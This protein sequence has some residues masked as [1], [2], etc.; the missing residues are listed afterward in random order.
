MKNKA[1]KRSLLI[2]PASVPL[3]GLVLTLSTTTT[4]TNVQ[5]KTVLGT[6]WTFDKVNI[7]LQDNLWKNYNSLPTSN[8]NARYAPYRYI[9]IFNSNGN[10]NFN[11][12]NANW[13]YRAVGDSWFRLF[14]ATNPGFPNNVNVSDWTGTNYATES[15]TLYSWQVDGFENK[16]VDH[17]PWWNGNGYNASTDTKRFKIGYNL[18]NKPLHGS[19]T[20]G[21]QSTFYTGAFYFSNDMKIASDIK[22]HLYIKVDDRN[23]SNV[24]QQKTYTI[25]LKEEKNANLSDYDISP[26]I[27]KVQRVNKDPLR[28]SQAGDTLEAWLT[29]YAYLPYYKNTPTSYT[30]GLSADLLSQKRTWDNYRSSDKHNGMYDILVSTPTNMSDIRSRGFQ[31]SNSSGSYV[32]FGLFQKNLINNDRPADIIYNN[33]GGLFVFNIEMDK[34]LDYLVAG[35]VA[36]VEFEPYNDVANASTTTFFGNTGSSTT[37]KS[38]FGSAEYRQKDDDDNQRIVSGFWKIADRSESQ[39]KKFYTLELVDSELG[40]D[41]YDPKSDAFPETTLRITENGNS[42]INYEINKDGINRNKKTISIK[43]VYQDTKAVNSRNSLRLTSTINSRDAKKWK[44]KNGSSLTASPLPSSRFD[45]DGIEFNSITYTYTDLELA[46]KYVDTK[47]WLNKGQKSYLKMALDNETGFNASNEYSKTELLTDWKT[48]IDTLDKQQESIEKKYKEI[49][50]FPLSNNVYDSSYNANITKKII[51]ALATK[52]SKDNL[53][54]IISRNINKINFRST[55]YNTESG[56]IDRTTSTEYSISNPSGASYNSLKSSMDSVYNALNNYLTAVINSGKTE[57]EKYFAKLEQYPITQQNSLTYSGNY[58]KAKDLIIN[59]IKDQVKDLSSKSR[60]SPFANLDA[61]NEQIKTIIELIGKVNKLNNDKN[62]V[63]SQ[64]E[65]YKQS[66]NDFN[67]LGSFEFASSTS[68]INLKALDAFDKNLTNASDKTIENIFEST[69]IL[70]KFYNDNNDIFAKQWIEKVKG[71]DGAINEFNTEIDKFNYLD[72]NQ[73]TTAKNDLKNALSTFNIFSYNDNTV[74]LIVNNAFIK[75]IND[76]MSSA[77]VTAKATAKT[78]ISA[79]NE[80]T[81]T[82]KNQVKKEIDNATLYKDSYDA[83]QPFVDKILIGSDKNIKAIV[84]KW[85]DINNERG[86]IKDYTATFDYPDKNIE[87]TT[88]DKK[89]VSQLSISPDDNGLETEVISISG[90]NDTGTLTVTYRVVKSSDKTNVYTQDKTYDITGFANEQNRVNKLSATPDYKDASEKPNIQASAV[91]NRNNNTEDIAWVLPTKTQIYA[92]SVRY[93]GY[94]DI[95]G[96]IKIAYKLQSTVNASAISDEKT[97]EITGFETESTR[98]NNLVKQDT[99]ANKN[100]VLNITANPIKRA[101]DSTLNTDYTIAL[102]NNYGTNNQV[103]LTNLSSPTANDTD[104][105]VSYTYKL[106][107]TRTK[108]DLV[109][110]TEE[111]VNDNDIYSDVSASQTRTG[112]LTQA[113]YEQNQKDAKK[114]AIDDYQSLND[115]QKTALKNEIDQANLDK[116]DKIAQNASDLNDA[117]EAYNG[118]TNNI[119][120]IKEGTDYTQADNDNKSALDNAVNQQKTDVNKT[121]GPNLSLEE[122]KKRTKAIQ[123]AISDLNGDEKLQEAKD[124]AI[125]KINSDYSSLTDKQ[126]EK[127]I[128]LINEQTTI[129]GVTTQDATNSELNSS[130]KTLRDYIAGQ[131]T[132]TAGDDYIYTTNDLRAAYDGNP[133]KNNN[134]KGGVIKEAEDLV[135]ALNTNNNDNLMNK[136]TIDALNKKIKGAIDALNGQ[137]RYGEELA[138]LNGLSLALAKVKD[139]N[140]ATDTASEVDTNEVEFISSTMPDN[141]TPV[142]LV[143]SNPN[144]LTGK[145][146]LSYKYQSTKE[147]LEN[148]KSTKVYTLNNNNALSTLTEQQRVDAILADSN[149]PFTINENDTNA[150]DRNQLPSAVAKE[151]I[152]A[153]NNPADLNVEG[154]L[155]SIE[156][157]PNNDNGTLN[158]TFKIAST[159]AILNSNNDP[160]NPAVVSTNTRTITLTG[161]KTTLQAEKEKVIEYINN[162]VP[163]AKKQAL[164]DELAN[165]NTLDEVAKVQL[166]AEIEKA[167]ADATNNYPYLNNNQLEAYKTDLRS[168]TS[169]EG[170]QTHSATASTLNAKMKELSDAVKTELTALTKKTVENDQNNDA[171]TAIV[172][173]LADADKKQAYD[174]ALSA[175]Q[176][177]LNKTNGA[178]SELSAVE[179]VLSN[180][181]TAYGELNGDQNQNA[182]NERID[183]LN[184]LTEKQKAQL[185]ENIANADAQADAETIVEAAETLDAKIAD[186]KKQLVELNNYKNNDVYKLDKENKDA[187]DTALENIQNALDELSNKD[188][189]SVSADD[190]NSEATNLDTK[191]S[192]ANQAKDLLDG[193]RSDLKDKLNNFDNLT[194]ANKQALINLINA[195]DKELS[196]EKVT[197]YLNQALNLAKTNVNN[198]ID[199]LTHLTPAEKQAYKDAVNEAELNTADGEK[200]DKNLNDIL[201]QAKADDEAKKALIKAINDKQYLNDAQKAALIDKVY[202]TPLAELNEFE[203]DAT[204]L[205]NAMKTYSEIATVDKE[206]IKYKEAFEDRQAEYNNQITNR[207]NALNKTDGANLSLD[208]VNE[209]IKKLNKAINNLNGE[210]RLQRAKN[211]AIAKIT[212]DNPTYT[213]LTDAQKTVLINQINAQTSIADVNAVDAKNKQIN[214]LTKMLK[215]NINGE[216]GIKES[217]HYTGSEPD[218]KSEY[219]EAIEA[220]KELLAKLNEPNSDTNN[221]VDLDR[222]KNQN[223]AVHDAI[224]A[225]NGEQNIKK[226]R[227]EALAKLEELEHINNLQKAALTTQIDNAT[228]PEKIDEIVANATNLN[229]QMGLLKEELANQAPVKDTPK[230]LNADEDPRNKYDDLLNE[231]TFL[232]D[233]ENGGAQLSPEAVADLIN[234][235]KVA[236]QALDGNEKFDEV[237]QQIIADIDALEHLNDAQKAALKESLNEKKLIADLKQVGEDAKLLDNAMAEIK[238]KAQEIANDLAQEGNYKYVAATEEPKTN[239]D[240]VKA[241]VDALVVPSG[242]NLNLKEVQDLQKALIAAEKALDGETN[243]DYFRNKAIEKIQSNPNLTDEEKTALIDQLNNV[244][245]PNDDEAITKEDFLNNLDKIV[246]KAK[247]IETIKNDDNLTPEQKTDLIDDIVKA[248]STQ[249]NYDDVLD[250]IKAKEDAYKTLNN[251]DSLTEDDKAKLS[252]NIADIEPNSPKFNEELNNEKIKQD[253]IKEI[254][255]DDNLPETTKNNLA[256]EI[257]ELDNKQAKSA[258]NYQIDKVKEKQK[259][260][261]EIKASNLPNEQKEALINEINSFKGNDDKA[262]V[263][264]DKIRD[265]FNKLKEI[266]ED[267]NLSQEDKAQ[268]VEDVLA[269]DPKDEKYY[270][271]A[272]NINKKQEVIDQVRQNPNLTQEQKDSISQNIRELDETSEEFTNKLENE[273]ARLDLIDQLHQEA[274]DNKI[275]DETRDKLISETLNLV[276]DSSF[277]ND[278]NNIKAKDKLIQ[279]VKESEVLNDTTKATLINNILDN[280]AT[281]TEFDN[282]HNQITQLHVDAEELAKAKNDLVDLTKSKKFEKLSKDKQDAINKAIADSDEILNNLNSYKNEDVVKQTIIDKKL[283]QASPILIWPYFVAASFVSWLIGMLI[284]VFGRKKK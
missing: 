165:A 185:K 271:I 9:N 152:K 266:Q 164:L 163:E 17:G 187:Y 179:T 224:D 237:K 192:E 273:K 111:V 54:S 170:I 126:K 97:A 268:L 181:Q 32:N 177:L 136:E 236:E 130:M 13:Q 191:V 101:S 24:L 215:D 2:V 281:S 217:I 142:D 242:N 50:D 213:D 96:K 258:L 226:R 39:R 150:I 267:P 243:Y 86:R 31:L 83:N 161:F 67:N 99:D 61:T 218:V 147:N 229:E 14:D 193:I 221:I 124:E 250:K 140:R 1:L 114:K 121:Q 202:K 214:D 270:E 37:N 156:L 66:Q 277:V 63:K 131:D 102:A 232:V 158:I 15:G 45:S 208:Q 203:N 122:V 30:N 262:P 199:K 112:F 3:A 59:T 29:N 195:D 44:V 91:V 135:D 77:F 119:E 10:Q 90:N 82:E 80:L 255:N 159:K 52:S 88:A 188:L 26:W 40:S 265:Q 235:I 58:N 25:K 245:S 85:T 49:R 275:S 129:D 167:I 197:D 162:N 145:L 183:A 206:S 7:D 93:L 219:D 141:V 116:L 211:E 276:N 5:S 284:F 175:A 166:K 81:E 23:N 134:Q 230:Y 174:N 168:A 182:L 103:E 173:T 115:A 42:N 22:I 4:S 238:A 89:L 148:V 254:R 274:K 227:E 200:Y 210:E 41:L 280:N 107:T 248:D 256:N 74:T 231:A 190:L 205:D 73:K 209:A 19:A 69:D 53:D 138:R 247:L 71:L 184:N 84:D 249:A 263:I 160:Q 260:I 43:S 57:I 78:K 64:I 38:F 154:Y 283:K 60:L 16:G 104:G 113:Q 272:K 62:S 125:R 36:E 257:A 155:N 139:A 12:T 75:K 269:N 201:T 109:T 198:E 261:D 55:E 171:K 65:N 100:T 172:Y 282:K 169:T 225:L 72:A 110:I 241:K 11:D 20:Q 79:L 21:A 18:V 246:D 186:T 105:S 251:D 106:K 234:N 216:S 98:L 35:A 28:A 223:Q 68:Q 207:D 128:A 123:D 194:P 222:I 196:A 8:H 133:A 252:E 178:N 157:S 228:S 144:E 56:A 47:Q 204:S 27:G 46:K 143:I 48:K 151:A 176:E 264:L 120:T 127:A 146:D 132:V 240:N 92:D 70:T 108:E 149:I 259:L 76:H 6:N 117:M 278:L 212:G 239:Y 180:L 220:A 118:A 189:T 51:Y 33:Q 153:F 253:A 244:Q 94:N 95:T 87:P 34:K 233:K 279:Q 137:E